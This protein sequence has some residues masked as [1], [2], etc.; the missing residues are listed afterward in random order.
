[1]VFGVA[2]DFVSLLANVFDGVRE[3]ADIGSNEK[4]C[5]SD[6]VLVQDVEQSFGMYSGSVVE[7]QGNT[8]NESAIRDRGVWYFFGKSLGRVRYEVPKICVCEG[9][10]VDMLCDAQ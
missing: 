5:G 8:G 2:S 4:K 10:E 1:M 3:F 6:T 9:R 7:S